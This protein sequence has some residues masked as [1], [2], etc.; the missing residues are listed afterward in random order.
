MTAPPGA[1]RWEIG[2]GFEPEGANVCIR[3]S[4]D[5]KVA[6]RRRLRRLDA[7]LSVFHRIA[8][9]IYRVAHNQH[10]ADCTAG[11]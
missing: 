7:A 11:G 10:V 4:D 5:N 1:T 2:H 6:C 8:K 3:D 9:E